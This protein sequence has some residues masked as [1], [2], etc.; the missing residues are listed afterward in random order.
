MGMRIL[1]TGGAGYIGST[2]AAQLLELG[3]SVVVIDDLRRGHRAAVPSGAEL[4]V[5]NVG[6][7]EALERAFS[8]G[9]VD[10]VMHFAALAE[11]GE[12]MKSPAAYFG[13][14]T[15]N[16]LRL[17]EGM[18]ANS[19]TKIVFSSTAAVFGSPERTPIEETAPK[20]PTNPYGESKLQVEQ[21]L[22]WFHQIHGLRYATLRYFNVAGGSPNRGED[23]HPESHLIPRI[24]QVAL[25]Q[26]KSI[27]IFGDDYPTPDGTCVRD[28]IHV[29][30]LAQAHVLALGALENRAPLIYNLGNGK[31]F[32]VQEVVE[33]A[34]RVTG[35]AIPAKIEARRPGDPPVLVASSEKIIRELGWKPK[36]A[37]LETIIASAW[38]WHR[39]HPKGYDDTKA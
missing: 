20:R 34:R 11:V 16:T 33:T 4:V 37:A 18:L 15:S 14:N 10:A 31:G 5:G 17:L 27:K 22:A 12:S 26:H 7:S 2:V 1:V 8:A 38:E 36:Y 39:T 28:Y 29:S 21:M 19:V 35:D 6:D 9:A 30:D 23:H 32:S 13:N 25:G 24:L 3:H